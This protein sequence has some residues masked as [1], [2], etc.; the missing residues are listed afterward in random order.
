MSRYLVHMPLAEGRHLAGACRG[1]PAAP[2]ARLALA[3]GEW[4]AGLSRRRTTVVPVR[5]VIA[6]LS[7]I[8]ETIPLPRRPVCGPFGPSQAGLHPPGQAEYLGSGIVRLDQDAISALATLAD[9]E[10][11]KATLTSAGP[12]LTVG[13]DTYLAREE[14][15]GPRPPGTPSLSA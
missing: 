15:P 13:N 11:F 7:L 12:V 8:L 3:I 9:G 10:D 14:E 2:H 4:L 5:K 1:W 6:D